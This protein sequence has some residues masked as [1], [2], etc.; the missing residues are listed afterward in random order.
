[1]ASTQGV[2]QLTLQ[3]SPTTTVINKK[4]M[5]TSNHPLITR[6]TVKDININYH[7]THQITNIIIPIAVAV[8][9]TLH[10]TMR[11][12]MWMATAILLMLQCL[13][14]YSL[15][16]NSIN[17]S[18]NTLTA[19]RN[20]SWVV[21]IRVQFSWRMNMIMKMILWELRLNNSSMLNSQ[22]SL[23]SSK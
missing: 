21:A 2:T 8:T 17:H 23:I 1:M 16:L 3:L 11:Q 15:T 5:Q 19:A 13:H 18:K 6:S 4:M 20:C 12:S 14:S 22:H 9:I 7:L 10:F